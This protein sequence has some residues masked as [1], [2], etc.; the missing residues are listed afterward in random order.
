MNLLNAVGGVSPTLSQAARN[1]KRSSSVTGH[2]FDFRG[3]EADSGLFFLVMVG[4]SI[5]F[6]LNLFVFY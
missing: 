4:F 2:G 6:Y 3:K 5:R 1:S